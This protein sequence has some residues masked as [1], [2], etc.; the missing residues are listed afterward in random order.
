[1][2]KGLPG[3]IA[4]NTPPLQLRTGRNAEDSAGLYFGYAVAL[5][6]DPQ[7]AIIPETA[8][9]KIIG[10]VNQNHQTA[11]DYIEPG[12]E[13]TYLA[14]GDVFVVTVGGVS[15]DDPVY[16]HSQ[17]GGTNAG[18]FGTASE[19]TDSVL[20]SDSR[21]LDET[22]AGGIAKLSLTIY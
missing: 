15:P 7:G 18:K 13:F 21:W 6:D 19:G 11:K 1:M 14:K 3:G 8:T 9:S 16:V 20:L 22:E 10:V 5:G 4:A 17:G 12:E 2:G